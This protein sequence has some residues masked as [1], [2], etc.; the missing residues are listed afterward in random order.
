[1]NFW[2][3]RTWWDGI[4]H[5]SFVREILQIG[6]LSCCYQQYVHK[7]FFAF[8]CIYWSVTGKISIDEIRIDH[9]TFPLI[10]HEDELLIGLIVVLHSNVY[11][12][13]VFCQVLILQL[14]PMLILVAGI[15]DICDEFFLFVLHQFLCYFI[16]FLFVY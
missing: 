12:L 11:L 5:L 16:F 2:V 10:Q 7:I 4:L 1:M 8:V 6:T 15:C 14:I 9:R 13:Q 3:G